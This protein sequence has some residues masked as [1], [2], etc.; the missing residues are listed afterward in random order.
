MD[1][2]SDLG[3]KKAVPAL[4]S[5]ISKKGTMNPFRK[6]TLTGMSRTCG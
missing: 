6:K 1:F 5:I 3:G 4:V 2:F